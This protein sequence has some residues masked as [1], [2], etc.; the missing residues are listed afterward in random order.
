MILGGNLVIDTV[1]LI[2][3]NNVITKPQP[4]KGDL[5]EAPKLTS[6]NTKINW[7]LDGKVI[8]S[9]IRGLSP[10]PVAWSTL[11]NEGKELKVKIYEASFEKEEHIKPPRW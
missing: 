9:F 3:G 11:S 1:S 6:E 5:K 2:E 10:Y 7:S 4:K 8:D